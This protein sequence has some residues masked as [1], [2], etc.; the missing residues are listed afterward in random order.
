MPKMTSTLTE[1]E[2]IIWQ[3]FHNGEDIE[4]ITNL[5][6]QEH[7]EFSEDIVETLVKSVYIKDFKTD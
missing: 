2:A 1:M 6:I 4:T 3:R 7:P 5:M